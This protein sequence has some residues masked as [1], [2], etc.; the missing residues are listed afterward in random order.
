[1]SRKLVLTLIHINFNDIN[2]TLISNGGKASIVNRN[3]LF[4][5][6]AIKKGNMV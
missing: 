5:G 2:L 3:V 4:D 1:M 6:I